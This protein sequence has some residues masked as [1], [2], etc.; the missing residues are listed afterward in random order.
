MSQ[1]LPSSVQGEAAGRPR[2]SDGLY[3]QCLRGNEKRRPQQPRHDLHVGQEPAGCAASCHSARS[4]A[5]RR[6]NREGRRERGHEAHGNVQSVAA[7]RRRGCPVRCSSL[8]FLFLFCFVC[9]VFLFRAFALR[10][11]VIG[12]F[13]APHHC[14]QI[15]VNTYTCTPACPS[16][17]RCSEFSSLRAFIAPSFFGLYRFV[18]T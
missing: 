12:S 18:V 11:N 14:N 4:A 13:P 10:R 1:A 15:T 6:P 8:Y 7:R 9:P 5:T 3:R 17:R 16:P 2:G